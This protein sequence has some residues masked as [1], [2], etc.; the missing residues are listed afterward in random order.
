MN[1]SKVGQQTEKKT[2]R[3]CKEFREKGKGKRK[4]RRGGW[5]GGG[6]K[7]W[8]GWKGRRGG[9]KEGGG[10]KEKKNR[11]ATKGAKRL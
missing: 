8:K 4:T 5:K 1:L 6:R 3:R 10:R 2:G 11:K 7:N 9:R